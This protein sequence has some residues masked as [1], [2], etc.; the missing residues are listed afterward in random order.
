MKQTL[1]ALLVL[2]AI[3]L[4]AC[5]TEPSGAAPAA[6]PTAAAAFDAVAAEKAVIEMEKKSWEIYKNKQADEFRKLATPKYRAVQ[7]GGIKDLDGVIKD[8][9]DG[10]INSYSLSDIKVEFPVNDTAILTYN[11]V[12]DFVYKGK[13]SKDNYFASSVWA[14]VNGTWKAAVYHETKVEPQPKK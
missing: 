3:T 4:C 10:V 8:M 5:S 7:N 1:F 11:L 6:S 2:F 12:L 13:Q 14:N 9:N